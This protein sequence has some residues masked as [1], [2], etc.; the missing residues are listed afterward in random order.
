MDQDEI[1]RR[2]LSPGSHDLW[3]RPEPRGRIYKAVPYEA[4]P[5]L[6]RPLE[7]FAWLRL[8]PIRGVREQLKVGADGETPLPRPVGRM[9]EEIVAAAKRE[10]LT[11]PPSYA[12]FMNDASLHERVPTCSGCY[13]DVPTKL[14]ALPGG[15]PGKLLRFLNDQQCGVLW[16]LHLTADGG[17]SVACAEPAN[18]DEDEGEGETL[19][20]FMKLGDVARCAA[21]FEEFVHRF[22]MENTL[23][24][25]LYEKTRAPLTP[26]QQAYVDAVKKVLPNL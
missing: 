16:Y 13:L 10:G 21:S 24:F 11:V 7:P 18:D 22:W 6:S 19:D 17:C 4:L 14:V 15:Q 26:E 2:W 9:V 5:T 8:S 20:D 1:P 23:W 25:S 3:G 12:T